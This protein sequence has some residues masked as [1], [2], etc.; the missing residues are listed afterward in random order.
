[1]PPV[2]IVIGS[3]CWNPNHTKLLKSAHT[4]T[5]FVFF[6]RKACLG[7]TI[8]WYNTRYIRFLLF[9]QCDRSLCS[10]RQLIKCRNR[11]SS[12]SSP[13]SPQS[14]LDLTPQFTAKLQVRKALWHQAMIH[15]LPQLYFT[16]LCFF[17]LWDLCCPFNSNLIPCSALPL[18]NS[19]LFYNLCSISSFSLC[20]FC[21]LSC[22]V[23]GDMG[24]ILH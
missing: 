19:P 17:P 23:M 1:M 22:W 15:R 12:W 9:I 21:I 16:Y 10:C 14:L 18:F 4:S 6:K 20:L 7:I 11:I 8:L 13:S 3:M 24:D 5:S 2:G